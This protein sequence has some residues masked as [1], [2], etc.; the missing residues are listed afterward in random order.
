MRPQIQPTVTTPVLQGCAAPVAPGWATRLRHSLVR[1]YSAV[2]R[3][4]ELRRDPVRSALALLGSLLLMFVMG[5]GIGMDVESLRFAVLD[6]DQTATSRAYA[7]NLSGSRFCQSS[8]PDR[9]CRAECAHAIG[10]AVAG[11]RDPAR[12]WRAMWSRAKPCRL[13]P[14]WTVPC[15]SAHRPCWAT[16]RACTSSGWSMRCAA[17]TGVAPRPCWRWK[18]ATATT[19]MCAACPPWCL[20]SSRCCCSCC[21]PC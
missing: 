16:C 3:A 7:L 19:P 20:P 12:L 11:H 18:P 21:P 17:R 8:R 1:I 5:Y 14:G 15:P 4:L 6:R 2:A 10:R 13:P 9:I